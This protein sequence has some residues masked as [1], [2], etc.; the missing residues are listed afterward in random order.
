ME[1]ESPREFFATMFDDQIAFQAPTRGRVL[2]VIYTEAG[3]TF[4][5]KRLE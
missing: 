3:K 2:D 1:A 5:A 4:H